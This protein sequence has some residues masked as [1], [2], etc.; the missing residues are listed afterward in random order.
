M[1]HQEQATQKTEEVYTRTTT[2][3]TVHS[4]SQTK[5]VMGAQLYSFRGGHHM[6]QA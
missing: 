3:V 5:V 6:S 2:P 1:E 4:D